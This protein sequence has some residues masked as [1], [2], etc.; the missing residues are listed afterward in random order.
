M[1]E[2]FLYYI[3]KFRLFQLNFQLA[4]GEACQVIDPGLRNE[5][6][7]PDFFNAK[8]KIGKTLWAGNVEIHVK[9]SDWQKHNHSINEAYDN[10]ILHVVYI[11]DQETYAKNGVAIPVLE[12]IDKFNLTVYKRYEGFM[13]SNSWIPCEKMF[14]SV[15]RFHINNWLD[16]LMIERLEFKS[17]EIEDQLKL[18]TNNWE[19]AFYEFIARNF[20]FK[21]NA[22]PF[23]LLAKSLPMNILARHKNNKFQLEALL[24]GQAGLIPEKGKD[25]YSK[26]LFNEYQ[27]LKMKY[28]LKTIET[29]LWRFMRLRPSNFPTIRIAQ[30]AELIFKSSHLFSAILEIEKVNEL[31]KLFEVGVS[32]YWETHYVFNKSAKKRQHKMSKATI[33][34]IL[35]NTIIPFL[36]IYG[37]LRKDAVFSD[38]ALRFLEQIPGENNI[39]VRNWGELGM[40]VQTAF[41][42]QALL[43]LKNNYCSNKQ[44]L[45]CSI[46]NE[47]LKNSN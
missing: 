8:I 11:H 14:N 3:W 36:F 7:G 42:T 35:I 10:V 20:G 26:K 46:G 18:N 47:I 38:R 23:E 37:K 29:H 17:Q 40:S 21:V 41:N 27:F 30:F 13:K 28:E 16:R 44:C 43:Q 12:L 19:Q 1:T 25:D 34:L 32:D 15:S 4:S 2:E 45:N 22:M 5:H 6:S 9:S 39:I 24:F 33:N 31:A